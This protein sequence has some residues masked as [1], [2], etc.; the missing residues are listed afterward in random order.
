MEKIRIRPEVDALKEKIGTVRECI[1]RGMIKNHNE[2]KVYKLVEQILFSFQKHCVQI[3]DDAP[4]C[5]A[6]S[7]DIYEFD[8][9][10]LEEFT[11]KV[12][13]ELNRVCPELEFVGHCEKSCAGYYIMIEL[14]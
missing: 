11:E 2:Q 14:M 12:V 9:T 4:T 10:N 7:D 3:D 13:K 6:F 8:T 5:I 1:Q